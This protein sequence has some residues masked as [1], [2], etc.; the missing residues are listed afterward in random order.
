MSVSTEASHTQRARLVRMHHE[1]RTPLHAIIGYSEILLEEAASQ[2]RD[3]LLPDLER[4]QRAGTRL[5]GM[6]NELLDPT[7]GMGAFAAPEAIRSSI[8]H[9][10][11]TPLNHILGY[12]E[13][14]QEDAVDQ[15]WDDLLP[16]L[17]CIANSGRELLS[18]LD[19]LLSFIDPNGT[20]GVI[21]DDPLIEQVT[22]TLEQ[23]FELLAEPPGAGRGHVL[24][25]DDN[26]T[27]RDL[28]TRWLRR[29]GYSVGTAQNGREALAALQEAPCDL[30]LLDVM[31]PELNGFEVLQRIKSDP[32]LRH[33][34][35]L[36]VSA[37]TEM[38][39]VVRC[40]ALGAED[41]LTKPFN[42][43]LLRARVGACL[44]KKRLRDREV[45]HLQQIERERQR[46]DD[47]LHVIFPAPIVSELKSTDTVKP[48]LYENVGVLFC[49]VV[50]FTPYCER[51]HPEEVIANLQL[52][53]E[54]YE[55]VVLEHGLQKIKTVGDSFMATA[56]LLE[57]VEQP[58]LRCVECGLRMVEIAQSLPMCWDVR[59]GIHLGSVIAGKVGH[60]QYLFDLWGDTVNTA[61]RMESHGAPGCVSVSATVWDQIAEYY[62]GESRGKVLVKGKGA[63]DLYRVLGP[64]RGSD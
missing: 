52:L 5:L 40:I 37:M 15:G 44:E 14:L 1:L 7:R 53:I 25:V 20:A 35:V 46:A 28:L 60:R 45:L 10:L 41:Y 54:A 19:Q 21:A 24:V 57:P 64:R 50:D 2:H 56:G 63:M 13:M 51:S 32:A 36:M 23:P 26:E 62:H 31:M 59:V 4:I 17:A 3:T 12:C 29:E 34:P 38:D 39:G 9:D 47:L 42:P 58:A 49:D 27:N 11:R 55:H 8:R 22:T 6:V 18:L 33:L 30:L 43:V 16:E 61:S 48:Q